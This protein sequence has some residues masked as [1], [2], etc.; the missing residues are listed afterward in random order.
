M[1]R[2][3]STVK[4]TLALD[5]NLWIVLDGEPLGGE[6]R[7]NLLRAIEQNGSITAGAKAIGVSYKSAW[8]HL[9]AM[10][11]AAGAPLVERSTGGRGG[12]STRLTDYGERLLN[13]FELISAEHRRYLASLSEVSL[14][15]QTEF[16]A[17]A[18]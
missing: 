3:R 7:F 15:L 4:P 6:L 9:D 5:G 18:S 8:D 14:D 12:G 2:K 17:A 1:K 11:Q 16:R 13:R 10:N